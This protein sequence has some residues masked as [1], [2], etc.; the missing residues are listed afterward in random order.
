MCGCFLHAPSWGPG[1]QRRHVPWLGIK[2]VTLWFT[3]RH[4]IHWAT[5]A[6]AIFVIAFW[7]TYVCFLFAKVVLTQIHFVSS[8]WEIISSNEL[9]VENLANTKNLDY[10]LKVLHLKIITIE[11][12]D[13]FF[14][15]FP[16]KHVLS[17]F[18]AIG[19]LIPSFCIA[20]FC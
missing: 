9:F 12:F 8:T 15:F 11:H 19:I 10:F 17:N 4:S 6:R 18:S 2:P 1:L 14:P 16:P 20:A 3:G 5:P 13:I 7:R